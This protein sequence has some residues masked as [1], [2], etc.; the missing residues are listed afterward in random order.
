MLES[1]YPKIWEGFALLAPAG[2]SCCPEQ[3]GLKEGCVFLL[4]NTSGQGLV[5]HSQPRV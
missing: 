5:L 3:K 4:P 2:V 1:K